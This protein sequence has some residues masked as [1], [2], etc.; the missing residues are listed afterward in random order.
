VAT[1]G[2]VVEQQVDLP[3][4]VCTASGE[5]RDRKQRAWQPENLIDRRT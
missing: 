2:T 5:L 4:P 3:P 1:A